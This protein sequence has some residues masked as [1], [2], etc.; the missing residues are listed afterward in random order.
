MEIIKRKNILC[1]NISYPANKYNK[2]HCLNN[3]EAKTSCP[4]WIAPQHR[5]WYSSFLL[6]GT[7]PFDRKVPFTSSCQLRLPRRHVEWFL[8]L[9]LKF[10]EL[11]RLQI[12]SEPLINWML[13]Q[14]KVYICVT[15]TYSLMV[16]AKHQGIS[17]NICHLISR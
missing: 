14:N 7:S 11:S 13:V 4:I 9:L 17:L 3:E 2:K 6:F 8:Q 1:Q 16:S 5:T 15:L 12:L 10:K